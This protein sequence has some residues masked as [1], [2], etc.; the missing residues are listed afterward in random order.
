MDPTLTFHMD[1]DFGPIV[2]RQLEAVRSQTYDIQYPEL[3]ARDMLPVD[4]SVDPGAETVK[5]DQYDGVGIAKLTSSYAE[6]VPLADVFKKEFRATVKGMV[7]GYQYSVQEVRASAMAEKMG[8][9]KP[10]PAARAER[11]KRAFEELV[12]K[13]AFAG[14]SANGLVG[15][16]AIPNAQTY[17]LGTKAAGGTSWNGATGREMLKDLNGIAAAQVVA[18]NNV[19][20]PDTMILPISM[21]NLAAET[22]VDTGISDTVLSYFLKTNPYIK[23]VVSWYKLETA[24]A[25]ATRRIIC[26]RKDPKKLQLV[27][28]MEFFQQPAQQRDFMWKTLCEGRIAG[29]QCYY[30]L[31]VSYADAG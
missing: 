10:L 31:S 18:T 19:E 16:N 24:G 3:K 4:N 28:P 30:P 21:F 13:I 14:D 8:M 1:A 2:D 17:T 27:I 23:S 15:L 12:E 7:T 11:A 22:P 26:Y 25:G 6:D 20:Q 29:V 5:Y 9:Q